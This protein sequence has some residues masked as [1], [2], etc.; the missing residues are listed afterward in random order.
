MNGD[1]RRIAGQVDREHRSGERGRQLA[2]LQIARAHRGATDDVVGEDLGERF[3]RQSGEHARI[4]LFERVERIV[5][6]CEHRERTVALQ[7]LD[8]PGAGQ[9]RRELR[10]VAGRV[11]KNLFKTFS[12]PSTTARPGRTDPSGSEPERTQ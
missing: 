9:R 3:F 1:L 12:K 4:R 7:R 5:G 10:E 6:R 2:V 8:Q 11:I